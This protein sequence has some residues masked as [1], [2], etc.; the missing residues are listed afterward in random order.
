LG[1]RAG[2]GVALVL[3]SLLLAANGAAHLAA[4]TGTAA[5]SLPALTLT[6]VPATG[7]VTLTVDLTASLSPSSTSAQF[8]WSFGDGSTYRIDGV[9]GSEMVHLYSDPGEYLVEVTAWSAAGTSEANLVVDAIPAPLV[10][11]LTESASYGT[12]PLTVEFHGSASGG[13]GTFVSEVWE[14]GDGQNGS[15]LEVNYTYSTAGTYLVNLTLVDSGGNTSRAFGGVTVAAAPSSAS[16][17]AFQFTP[18]VD[19][20]LVAIGAGILASVVFALGSS[21]RSRAFETAVSIPGGAAGGRPATG[22]APPPVSSGALPAPDVQET[23]ER[24]LAHLYWTG[25]RTGDSVGRGELT[26]E[27]IAKELRVAPSTVGRALRR[28]SDGGA[29]TGSFD[30]VPGAPRRVWCY[31]L[32]PR[33]EAAARSLAHRSGPEAGTTNAGVPDPGGSGPGSPP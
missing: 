28:L 20:A 19:I 3:L 10:A 29:V 23:Y 16:G 12:A 30:H 7:P 26:R 13:T 15:G 9:G 14:F 8:N 33:G 18:T 11:T 21:R 32:T 4:A 5:P 1:G 22:V 24:V 6:A 17:P 25:R 2:R 27:G 31:S